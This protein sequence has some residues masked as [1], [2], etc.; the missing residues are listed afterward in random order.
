VADKWTIARND[1][2]S[3]YEVHAA[4]CKHLI[5]SYIEPMG[6]AYDGNP[7][8][9]AADFNA[10]NDGC[11]ALLGPCAKA[12][13]PGWKPACCWEVG[14]GFCLAPATMVAFGGRKVPLCADHAAI[15]A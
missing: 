11:I 7:A 13:A 8:D 1:K 15:G 6:P 5:A 12:A 3:F 14:N 2:T 9:I 4:G 10:S